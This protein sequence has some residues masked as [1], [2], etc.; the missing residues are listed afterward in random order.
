VDYQR[1]EGSLVSAVNGFFNRFAA[2]GTVMFVTRR[3]DR[4]NR[5]RIAVVG[6]RNMFKII[7][8]VM[9]GGFLPAAE[10]LA[11][12]VA[13]VRAGTLMTVT[14]EGGSAEKQ[15]PAGT[16]LDV[17]RDNG[18]TLQ[19]RDAG[20]L[21]GSIA[22][23]AVTIGEVAET[24]PQNAAPPPPVTVGGSGSAPPPEDASTG[25]DSPAALNKTFGIELFAD[26]DLWLD[27]AAAAAGRLGWPQESKTDTQSSYRLYAKSE[28]RVLGARPYS[29]VMYAHGGKADSLSMIFANKGDFDGIGKKNDAKKRDAAIRDFKDAVKDDA[30]TIEETLTAALGAPRRQTFGETPETRES[31]ARWD[32]RSHAILLASPK[33]EYVAVR[34]VQKEAADNF[35]RASRVEGLRELLQ[36]HVVKR[37]NGDVVIGQIPMVNQ[38]PKGYCVPATWERYLRYM[39]I[40]AD[41]YLLAMAGNTGLGGGTYVDAITSNVD[42]YVRRYGCKIQTVDPGLDTKNI[43]RHVDKGLPLMWTCYVSPT[44]EKAITA[45][46]A[47]RRK[48]TDWDAYAKELK[49]VKKEYRDASFRDRNRAHMRMI[50]GYNAKTG[51]I[52]IS[53]SWGNWAAERWL[54]VEEAV[55]TTQGYLC[56]IKW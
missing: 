40:P 7:T 6:P 44:V 56:V 5:G 16:V 46:T 10:A 30:R 48:A 12:T 13:T 53:D 20:G 9:V 25:K 2:A 18:D 47:E 45:R 14:L 34:I 54:T 43:A 17:L 31:V 3:V 55:S 36:G 19:V 4:R 49:P 51:E 32:W 35:G 37:D 50:I 41:M 1:H 23:A 29:L 42:I 27:D 11:R 22:K 15:V 21:T 38:G 26:T 52:A 8:L 33:D 24:V 28:A 39:E